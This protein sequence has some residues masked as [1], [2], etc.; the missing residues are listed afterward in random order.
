MHDRGETIK[1]T[2]CLELPWAKKVRRGKSSQSGA[3]SRWRRQS[4][5]EVME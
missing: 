2:L 1:K 3:Q 5:D 4:S